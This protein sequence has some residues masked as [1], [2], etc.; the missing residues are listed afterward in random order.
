LQPWSQN[1][2]HAA[3]TR[4]DCEQ[5]R[6]ADDDLP[7]SKLPAKLIEYKI[8]YQK[9]A[10]TTATATDSGATARALSDL[11]CTQREFQPQG[12]A[13]DCAGPCRR[14]ICVLSIVSGQYASQ[15]LRS[16]RRLYRHGRF[17]SQYSITRSQ[18]VQARFPVEPGK[19]A[20][21]VFTASSVNGDAEHA[22]PLCPNSFTPG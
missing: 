13:V 11:A 17:S 18:R 5:A 2:G 15:C 22:M 6:M 9:N 10:T 1:A 14:W 8:A 3:V 4:G 7:R 12:I 21:A 19:P 16:F 20:V